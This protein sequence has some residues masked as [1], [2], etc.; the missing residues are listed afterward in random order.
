MIDEI[1][2]PPSLAEAVIKLDRLGE[3][4][5]WSTFAMVG[6]RCHYN[7]MSALKKRGWIEDAAQPA[8]SAYSG[9]EAPYYVHP[10][11]WQLTEAGREAARIASSTVGDRQ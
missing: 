8:R 2:I 5:H 9:D 3:S 7:A 10:P 11:R 6:K 1:R 4:R